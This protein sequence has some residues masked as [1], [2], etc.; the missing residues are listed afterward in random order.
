MKPSACLAF[1]LV[2]LS[3]CSI[4]LGQRAGAPKLREDIDLPAEYALDLQ[5]GI[6]QRSKI[7]GSH[8][9]V[10]GTPWNN[11]SSQVMQSFLDDPAVASLGLPYHWTLEIVNDDFVN[12]FSTAGGNVGV[13]SGLAKLMGN[14]PGL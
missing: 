6:A 8:S 7:V 1:V 14:D 5:L 10:E 12:A 4:A 9:L 2:L 3:T 11:V 13:H